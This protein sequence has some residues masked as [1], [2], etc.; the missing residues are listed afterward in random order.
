MLASSLLWND[1]MEPIRKASPSVMPREL[2]EHD[3]KHALRVHG[4]RPIAAYSS[5]ACMR[6]S[7]NSSETATIEPWE[8]QT[9]NDASQPST[10]VVKRGEIS[11]RP[12]TDTS[13]ANT[14]ELISSSSA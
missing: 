10:S 13:K 9:P 8:V 4:F 1:L 14:K 6:R 5:T 2:K 12:M 11:F 7:P 3:S